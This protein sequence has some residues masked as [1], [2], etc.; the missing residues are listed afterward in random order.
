MG[1]VISFPRTKPNS[2]IITIT[3]RPDGS[4]GY[5]LEEYGIPEECTDYKRAVEW[6]LEAAVHFEAEDGA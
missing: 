1:D 5:H 3:E 4:L 2:M 6:L